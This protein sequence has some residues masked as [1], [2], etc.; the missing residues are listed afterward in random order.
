MLC[1]VARVVAESRDALHAGVGDR[2]EKLPEHGILVEERPGVAERDLQKLASLSRTH[3]RGAHTP[4]L[5]RFLVHVCCPHPAHVHDGE[6]PEARARRK[7]L[8]LPPVESATAGA[9]R[10]KVHGVARVSPPRHKVLRLHHPRF[11]FLCDDLY[12][13][14]LDVDVG[15]GEEVFEHHDALG[16]ALLVDG[17]APRAQLHL[18]HHSAREDSEIGSF[19]RR[20]GV[21][22]RPIADTEAADHILGP[23]SVDE[24]GGSRVEGNG[25]WARSELIESESVIF[26]GV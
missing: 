3:I 24:E 17:R 12:Q 8:Q 23:I 26:R 6:F 4:F 1:L 20:E 22:R 18:S 16:H 2:L 10:E 13:A 7:P 5:D 15:A 11:C 25:L 21:P 9:A 14:R 19:S